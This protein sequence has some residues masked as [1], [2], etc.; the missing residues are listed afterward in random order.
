MSSQTWTNNEEPAFGG[1]AAHALRARYYRFLLDGRGRV[2]APP[3]GSVAGDLGAADEAKLATS[4]LSDQPQTG[5]VRRDGGDLG[6]VVDEV[7]SMPI[8]S[9]ED[10]STIAAIVLGFKPPALGS[11]TPDLGLAG[12]IWL[13]GSLDLPAVPEEVRAGLERGLAGE[14]AASGG[15]HG[16]FTFAGAGRAV[17]GLVQ[18]PEP[19]IALSSRLRGLRAAARRVDRPPAPDRLGIRGRWRARPLRGV[20]REPLPFGAPLEARGAPRGRFG[21][22]PEPEAARRG[23]AR[24]DEPRG[25]AL[26][27]GSPRT[28]PTS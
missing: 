13:D 2:I 17:P 10:G 3:A 21:G 19:R 18:E 9:S 1:P 28:P 15:D 7:I 23:G 22:E 12:G 16:G 11:R 5:Y 8:V 26:G 27:A 6:R 24:D 20:H 14:I 25:P 4:G